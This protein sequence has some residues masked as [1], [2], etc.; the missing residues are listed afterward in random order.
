[1][2]SGQD[3]W[4][5]IKAP[6]R[7]FAFFSVWIDRNPQRRQKWKEVCHLLDLPDKFIEYDN[8]TRW[9][10]RTACLPGLQAKVQINKYLEL[11]VDL[12]LASFTDN[13]WK[14]LR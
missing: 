9:N 4:G 3:P 14:R 11:Q 5:R 2:L 1:M 7:N 8:D 6:W 10:S 12:P 13:D